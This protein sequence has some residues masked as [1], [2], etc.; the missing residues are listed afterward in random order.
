MFFL[1]KALDREAEVRKNGEF[2]L[3]L[4]ITCSFFNMIMYF[5]S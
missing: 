5:K 1:Y 3:T 4:S 2:M